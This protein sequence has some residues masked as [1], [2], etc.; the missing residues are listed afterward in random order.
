MRRPRA[1]VAG[2]ALALGLVGAV[3]AQ[4]SWE[5]QGRELVGKLAP[6]FAL[7]DTTGKD[8]KLSDLKG[9]KVVLLDFGS[10]CRTCESVAKELQELHEAYKGKPL[11]IVTVSAGGLPLGQLKEWAQR[12]RLTYRILGDLELK[13]AEAYGLEV[14]PFTVIV[15]HTGTVRWVHTGH[16]DD[17]KDRLAKQLDDWLAKVPSEQETPDEEPQETPQ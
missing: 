2:V 14:I 3:A 12:T 9:K 11:E 6:D 15:D 8:W 17:Y 5:G 13:G 1:I 7:R 10:T 16:P 4:P